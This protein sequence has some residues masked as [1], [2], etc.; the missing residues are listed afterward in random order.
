MGEIKLNQLVFQNLRQAVQNGQ[1]SSKE[2]KMLQQRLLADQKLDDG[3][4]KLHEIL[5]SGTDYNYTIRSESGESLEINPS[6]LSLS[7][8]RAKIQQASQLSTDFKQAFTQALR[9]GVFNSSDLQ[10]LQRKVSS[11]QDQLFLQ[12]FKAGQQSVELE[13]IEGFSFKFNKVAAGGYQLDL[14]Q[15][16]SNVSNQGVWALQGQDLDG[17][18]FSRFGQ[19]LRLDNPQINQIIGAELKNLMSKAAV[20]NN[21]AIL[22]RLRNEG[23]HRHQRQLFAQL[24]QILSEQVK[25]DYENWSRSLPQAIKLAA[26]STHPT[27]QINQFE[28]L[29][30]QQVTYQK[31]IASGE[32]GTHKRQLQVAIRKAYSELEPQAISTADRVQWAKLI[33]EFDRAQASQ[34]LEPIVFQADPNQDPHEHANNP[35]ESALTWLIAH[36]SQGDEIA[37]KVLAGQGKPSAAMKESAAFYMREFHRGQLRDYKKQLDSQTSATER[38]EAIQALGGLKNQPQ[39]VAYLLR[40]AQNDAIETE[41]RWAAEGAIQQL[42]REGSPATAKVA[43]EALDLIK[44]GYSQD[45]GSDLQAQ[46]AALGQA[47][48]QSAAR[49]ELIERLETADSVAR[50]VLLRQMKERIKALPVNA[51]A[52]AKNLV[53][54][55]EQFKQKPQAAL[56]RIGWIDD[57]QHKARAIREALLQHPGAAAKISAELKPLLQDYPHFRPEQQLAISAAQ[58]ASQPQAAMAAF[59]TLLTNAQLSP[60]QLLAASLDMLAQDRLQGPQVKILAE[61]L[62]KHPD[63][64]LAN[65]GLNSL[66]EH[67]QLD[68]ASAAIAMKH[69]ELEVRMKAIAPLAQALTQGQT[70]ALDLLEQAHRDSAISEERRQIEKVFDALAKS[71]NPLAYEASSALYRVTLPVNEPLQKFVYSDDKQAAESDKA[72]VRKTIRDVEPWISKWG[73][74]DLALNSLSGSAAEALKRNGSVAQK[75]KFINWLIKDDAASTKD[76][77]LAIIT[78]TQSKHEFDLLMTF[79]R[80]GRQQPIHFESYLGKDRFA[81]FDHHR[82]QLNQYQQNLQDTTSTVM[83]SDIQTKAD[84]MGKA[85]LDFKDGIMTQKEASFALTHILKSISTR[86][87]YE[88]VLTELKKSH[89]LSEDELPKVIKAEE[90]EKLRPQIGL[91][92]AEYT[93]AQDEQLRQDFQSFVDFL[94]E[95]APND[96]YTF[97]EQLQIKHREIQTHPFY[98]EHF[99]N[100]VKME[101]RLK[102]AEMLASG[103]VQAGQISGHFADRFFF[104]KQNLGIFDIPDDLRL[105]DFL[106]GGIKEKA[107]QLLAVSQ[108]A[109]MVHDTTRDTLAQKAQQ[110]RDLAASANLGQSLQILNTEVEPY[111]KDLKGAPAWQQDFLIKE[112]LKKTHPD[113]S[114]DQI[115]QALATLKSKFKM[116]DHYGLD[117]AKA[118]ATMNKEADRLIKFQEELGV[119]GDFEDNPRYFMDKAF[120]LYYT[121]GMDVLQN[122]YKQNLAQSSY[123]QNLEPVLKGASKLENEIDFAKSALVNVIGMATGTE[124]IVAA[125]QITAKAASYYRQEDLVDLGLRSREAQQKIMDSIVWDVVTLSLN[126]GLDKIT[127]GLSQ[128]AE[129]VIL[130]QAD[131]LFPRWAAD[132]MIKEGRDVFIKNAKDQFAR[133]ISTIKAIYDGTMA[134]AK[135]GDPTDFFAHALTKGLIHQ[136]LRTQALGDRSKIAQILTSDSFVSKQIAKQFIKNTTVLVDKGLEALTEAAGSSSAL[137]AI[138]KARADKMLKLIL[139]TYPQLK[140]Q[141]PKEIKT[142]DDFARVLDLIANQTIAPAN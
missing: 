109:K 96:D 117:A 99:R 139:E 124:W 51:Q 86:E 49:K 26:Q 71:D 4:K 62:L 136:S 69:P 123:A 21:T 67:R 110:L 106:K 82:D 76:Q 10:S 104:G 27:E 133:Q 135:S 102:L 16:K 15:L 137:N 111:F 101:T 88:E 83:F 25:G 103:Q 30:R 9:D 2:F 74:E 93:Y 7:T 75:A 98:R 90:F 114:E 23:V 95:F 105:R 140:A 38:Q 31:A 91:V 78:S 132:D 29:L 112:Q 107:A 63:D 97:A 127:T 66:I 100:G 72:L 48:L 41:E 50:D 5:S 43:L 18:R 37:R 57:P 61:R 131:E 19:L 35:R 108:F 24:E 34:I 13:L 94:S 84:L 52:Q 17:E 32:H 53:E 92:K 113:W 6:R 14:E 44:S 58:F 28:T 89:N 70:Y 36:S 138:E 125:A 130:K 59:E 64:K 85:M 142:L 3:E 79:L 42:A 55:Y 65:A 54:T 81:D 20:L 46:M 77:V 80:E 12:D 11:V 33:G 22:D 134:S 128:E 47:N 8:I 40:H 1:F 39:A 45:E 120:A 126:K 129:A 73:V 60:E 115:S 87:E 68:A 118:A 122:Q 141:V 116:V 121:S 56:Q 119:N